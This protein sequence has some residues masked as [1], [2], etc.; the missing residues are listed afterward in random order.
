M[1]ITAKELAKKL[2]L[3]AAAVSMA[4]NHKPGVSKETR[5]LVIDT[6]TRYG[7]DFTK[8]SYKKTTNGSIYFV[9]YKKYGAVVSD[10]TFFSELSDGVSEGCKNAGYKLNIRYLYDDEETIGRQIEDIQYSDCCGMILLGTEMTPEK[11]KS[12]S[13]LSLPIVL[14]DTYFETVTAN[15]VL[16]NNVQGA[17][18]ATLYLIERTRKQPGYFHSAY[19]IGNFEERASG[20]YNAIRASGMSASQSIVHRLTPSM[21]GAFADMMEIIESKESLAPCYFA[22][23]DLIAVGAM[24][25]LQ[26][27]GYK[28]P[29]DISIVGFD[30]ITFTKIVEPSLTTIHVP[31]QDMGRTAAERL[32]E[33]IETKRNLPMKIEIATRLIKRHSA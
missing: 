8:I 1:S 4:L 23:N 7:Y 32:I 14:L 25:A 18:M 24:K 9:K 10:T 27:K 21:E 11:Y 15:Y 20:F 5:Q 2:G 26:A 29:D 28:I 12:F 22:D 33:M 31:K 16:I 17:Y 6:A 3:S 19:S 13:S 30:N